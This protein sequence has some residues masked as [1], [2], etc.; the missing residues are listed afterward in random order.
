MKRFLIVCLSAATLSCAAKAA[1]LLERECP[2]YCTASA[3]PGGVGEI[4]D[5][6]GAVLYS[7]GAGYVP[8]SAGES[9]KPGDRV[10]V[11]D[12]RAELRLNGICH[13][14][15]QPH[16]VYTMSDAGGQ[17][18]AVLAPSDPPSSGIPPAIL[19]G[20]GVV[21][22]GGGT[23]LLISQGDPASP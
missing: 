21:V 6:Q 11:D 23:G 4:V 16:T 3:H 5:L 14:H 1:D 18:C 22:L 19:I 9:L 8:A 13:V 12:G 20:G 15:L 10:M 7:S 2:G 17:L